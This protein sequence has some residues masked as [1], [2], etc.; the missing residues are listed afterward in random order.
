[1]HFY[2]PAVIAKFLR[3]TA[4]VLHFG[5]IAAHVARVKKNL[6]ARHSG[7]QTVCH[8]PFGSVLTAAMNGKHLC[9]FAFQPLYVA[10][11]QCRILVHRVFHGYRPYAVQ[12]VGN[13]LYGNRVGRRA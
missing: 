8:L 12:S 3:F 4:Q 9:T 1:M 10:F 2:H 6:D 5:G 13:L 7:E 11:P